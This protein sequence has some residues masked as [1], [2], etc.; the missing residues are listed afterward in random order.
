MPAIPDSARGARFIGWG[1]SLGHKVLTNDELTKDMDTDDEWI[2]E[3]TGIHRRHIG[4]STAELST[5]SGLAALK[6]A[7]IDPKS[8]DALVLATTTPDRTVPATSATV[9][10]ALGLACGAFDVNAACSGFVYGLVVAHGLIAVGAER[11]MVIGTDSLSRIIDWTD[12]NTAPL[13]ADGSGAAIIEST[14][15]H[16]QLLGWDI[17]ADGSAE[18]ILY[19]EVGA[20]V[21]MNGKEVFRRAVRIMVDSAQKSLAAA[22]MTIDDVSVVVPHQANIRIISAA[23][24][25]LGIPMEKAA[26]SIHETGNTS[27]ASIPLALFGD[28]DQVKPKDGDVVLLVGFGAGMTAAS[29]VL[30]WNAQ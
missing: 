1:T 2:R 19:A 9:Q 13:F 7:G 29:A 4:G 26:I 10:N 24:E 18:E 6:M 14:K 28:F 17:D 21:Q 25:R 15:G 8:I 11:I 27:S 16:G 20:T 5:A 30:R 22:G 12:R 23:C 3:R